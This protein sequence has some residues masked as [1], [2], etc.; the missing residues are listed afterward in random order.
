MAVALIFCGTMA[1]SQFTNAFGWHT[2]EI[3]A[4]NYLA[5]KGYTNIKMLDFK[6]TSSCPKESNWVRTR[7]SAIDDKGNKITGCVCGAWI[8]DGKI[9][10]EY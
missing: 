2:D 6:V 3:G 7:F 1:F 4:T 9:L 8:D 5:R 10:V